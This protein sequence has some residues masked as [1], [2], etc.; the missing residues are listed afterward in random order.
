MLDFTEKAL[1]LK[2]GRFREADAWVRM[3]TPSRGV[4]TA[5][6]FGGM[7]SRRRFPGCLDPLNV[8]L[9]KFASDR[10]GRFLNLDEGTLLHG[11]PALRGK[12]RNLGVAVNC[13][14][15]VEAVQVGEE[16]AQASYGLLLDL[17]A[18]LEE[19]VNQP[20]A[21]PLLF[22]A[23][24]GF[25][26]GYRPDFLSCGGCGLA[27]GAFDNPQFF[28]EKGQVLCPSC[29]EDA[30]EH[31]GLFMSPGALRALDWIL[32][33]PPGEWPRLT[34]TPTVRQEFSRA[35][36]RFMAYHLGLEWENGSFRNV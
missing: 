12:T 14:K 20:E 32:T 35:V 23:R 34:V 4:L 3:L 10:R 25:S 2:V 7:K 6:A 21:L 16:G 27:V 11:H 33:H 26:Q 28:V 30:P 13:L 31:S 18:L 36:E 8:V 22:R 15:F 29:R 5:F 19:D 24:L 1:V 9:F 17:L